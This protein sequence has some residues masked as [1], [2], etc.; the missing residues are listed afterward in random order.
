MNNFYLKS[1]AGECDGA[2]SSGENGGTSI[3]LCLQEVKVTKTDV[4][5]KVIE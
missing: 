3:L 1:S 4:F 2:K 5:Y